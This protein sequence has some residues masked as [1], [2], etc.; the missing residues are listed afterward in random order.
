MHALAL[1]GGIA[2]GLLIGGLGH[3]LVARRPGVP[4][5]STPLIGVCGAF[6]GTVIAAV[7]GVP[8]DHGVHG[9]RLGMQT[10]GAVLAVVAAVLIGRRPAP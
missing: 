9:V 1:L 5:W 3:L 7:A 4:L 8:D 2:T 10:A 6:L